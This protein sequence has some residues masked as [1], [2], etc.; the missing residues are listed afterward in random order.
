MNN[1]T[2]KERKAFALHSKS[3]G[4][5]AT[6]RKYHVSLQTVTAARKEFGIVRESR[7]GDYQAAMVA[8]RDGLSYARASKIYGVS[9]GTLNRMMKEDEP[10]GGGLHDG[11]KLLLCINGEIGRSNTV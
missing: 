8:V 4:T 3:H 6:R 11:L 1:Y 10:M 2:K 5:R 9:S 7:K